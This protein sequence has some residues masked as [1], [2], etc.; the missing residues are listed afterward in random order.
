MLHLCILRIRCISEEEAAEMAGQEK[1]SLSREGIAS[2]IKQADFLPESMS[3]VAS[4]PVKR[5]GA[6]IDNWV[7]FSIGGDDFNPDVITKMLGIEPDRVFYPDEDGKNALWQMS[8]TVPGTESLETHFWEILHR[9]LPVRRELLKIAKEASL[10]FY[11]TIRKSKGRSGFLPLSP[12]V[13]ILIGYIGA[14]LDIEI[15][16]AEE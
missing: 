10:N 8:S 12:R 15:T 14:G 7:V 13:L 4:V 5:G 16:D 9:L 1:E 11:C 2:L 3:S 6:V